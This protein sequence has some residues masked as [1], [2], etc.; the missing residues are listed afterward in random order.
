RQD[1][2]HRERGVRPPGGRAGGAGRGPPRR[3]AGHGGPGLAPA[4]ARRDRA[5]R[6]HDQAEASRGRGG[7][8]LPEAHAR[9][10]RRPGRAVRTP[11]RGRLLLI[12]ASGP[13]VFT[14]LHVPERTGKPA[15]PIFGSVRPWGTAGAEEDMDEQNAT[16]PGTGPRWG[17]R[18]LYA[19]LAAG[20]LAT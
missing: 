19:I 11:S 10:R 9:R 5:H 17:R 7:R 14:K 16:T 8:A 15:G 12:P 13:L 3:L 6:R 18:I 20:L 2:V 1:A 4:Q